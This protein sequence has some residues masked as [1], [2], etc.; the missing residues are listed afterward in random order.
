M[1]HTPLSADPVAHALT[2]LHEAAAKADALGQ[3]DFF[4]TWS[5]FASQIRL[6]AGAI[7]P[8]VWPTPPPPTSSVHDCLTQALQALDR[9][10]PGPDLLMWIWHVSELRRLA[11]QVTT[12]R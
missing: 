2:R 9:T 6:V 3:G 10:P 8:T 4:S 7:D 1:T 5:A 12:W 11:E